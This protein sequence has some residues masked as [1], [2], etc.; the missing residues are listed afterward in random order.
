MMVLFNLVLD[1]SC[2]CTDSM[3]SNDGTLPESRHPSCL[4]FDGWW[5]NGSGIIKS[6]YRCWSWKTMD[7]PHHTTSTSHQNCQLD[8]GWF[9]IWMSFFFYHASWKLVISL[10]NPLKI[11]RNHRKIPTDIAIDH[12]FSFKL[13][14]FSC[15]FSWN[16]Y[17]IWFWDA[18]H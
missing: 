17:S 4:L 5:F 2:R 18:E 12:S 6:K 14:G 3:S 10:A 11:S 13:I 1:C 8:S 15:I 9:P 7:Y 16:K